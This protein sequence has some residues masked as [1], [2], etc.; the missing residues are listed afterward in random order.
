MGQPPGTPRP[1]RV[2]SFAPGTKSSSVRSQSPEPSPKRTR[3]DSRIPESKLRP[4]QM[5]TIDKFDVVYPDG[6]RERRE[7]L[8]NCRRGTPSRPCS[9]VE[10]V[11]SFEDRYASKAEVRPVESRPY[12]VREHRASERPRPRLVYRERPRGGLDNLSVLYKLWNPFSSKQRNTTTRSKQYLVVERP[13]YAE[14]RSSGIYRRREAPPS[15]RRRVPEER[16]KVGP[17]DSF[18]EQDSRYPAERERR[19]PRG[20]IQPTV[21]HRPSEE[22]EEKKSPSPPVAHRRHYR[23]RA[24]SLSPI[25]RYEAEKEILRQREQR[26]YAEKVAQVER[27]ARRRAERVAEEERQT[28]WKE[29]QQR[30]EIEERK[31][32]ESAERARRRRLQEE[33]ETEQARRNQEQQDIERLRRRNRWA[34]E[35][36][37]L[38]RA[39]RAYIPR[40]PRH[41]VF[42]H[43]ETF[44]DRGEQFIQDAIRAEN[45][46]QFESRVP[47]SAGWYRGRYEENG[48][49]RRYTVGSDYRRRYD[50]DRR[51]Y[52]GPFY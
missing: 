41:S 16:P 18:Q 12:L 48:P 45:L 26:Q 21:V 13:K 42:V 19:R 10:V 5:C 46:R 52:G 49:R 20:P 25:S 27:E 14:P 1:V 11:N 36:E 23:R 43:Q 28:F 47:P 7:Q 4:S 24:R 29:R 44:R 15:P 40:R 39:R 37:R 33:W 3:P 50:D 35:E 31:R 34:E 17:I 51:R 38:A 32:L 22:E 2:V 30:Q 6:T 8:R 9:Q